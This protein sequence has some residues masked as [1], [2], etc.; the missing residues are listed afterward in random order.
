M[1]QEDAWRHTENIERTNISGV[2]TVN[3][4]A[5]QV[6]MVQPCLPS[7]YAAENPTTRNS[8]LSSTQRKTADKI[9]EWTGQ[10]MSSLLCTADDRSRWAV[11]AEASVRVPERRLYVMGIRIT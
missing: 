7:R 5:S 10:L 9:K 11:T 3:R 6:I 4:Q 8:E 2:L 1:L